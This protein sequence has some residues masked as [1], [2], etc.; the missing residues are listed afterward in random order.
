[1]AW[2]ESRSRDEWLAEVKRRGE[3]IRRRRRMAVAF[4]GVLAL[5]LPLSALAGFVTADPGRDQQ[6]QVAGPAATSAARS[7]AASELSSGPGTTVPSEPAPEEAPAPTTTIYGLPAQTVNPLV[8]P[9]ALP[10]NGAVT[11]APPG[12]IPLTDDPVVRTTTTLTSPRTT[13][14]PPLLPNQSI[15]SSTSGG[16]AAR[17][18]PCPPEALQ[19]DVVPSK[20]T[21]AV[22]ETVS[23]TFFL[24]TRQASDCSVSLPSSF[25]IE[26]VASGKVLGAVGATTEFASP[27]RAEPGKMLTSTFSW[28]PADCSDS[29]CGQVAPGLYQ[30]V[31]VWSEGGPYRG[32]GEF[33][34]GG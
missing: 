21:F 19:I 26:E 13:T 5:F 34:I 10:A 12:S 24:Q 6:L 23:G 17:L 4:V 27:A 28:Y 18:A 30:A 32:W 25:R 31:A 1:M 33:R 20:A 2:T 9:P 22:G 3:R 16:A 14:S 7:R 11:L 29:S 8:E 15:A